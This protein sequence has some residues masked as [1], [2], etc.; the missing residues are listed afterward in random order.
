MNRTAREMS[1]A[2]RTPQTSHGMQPQARASL[3][4]ARLVWYQAVDGEEW[5]RDEA[6]RVTPSRIE[7]TRMRS[8]TLRVRFNQ[9]PQQ[10]ETRLLVW[11]VSSPG[12]CGRQAVCCVGGWSTL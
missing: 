11:R 6:G 12:H 9:Q 10:E 8:V 7:K 4:A 1:S 3:F 5:N 2:G